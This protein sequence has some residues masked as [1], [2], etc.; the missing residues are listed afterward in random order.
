ME[1]IM[2]DGIVIIDGDT[3]MKRDDLNHRVKAKILGGNAL[4]F[5][6]LKAPALV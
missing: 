3:L 5:Y 2:R 4:S 1:A 6:G